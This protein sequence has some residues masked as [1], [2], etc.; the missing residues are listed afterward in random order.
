MVGG[1]QNT[2]HRPHLVV[3][4]CAQVY[5]YVLQGVQDTSQCQVLVTVQ[6]RHTQ[7]G[8]TLFLKKNIIVQ[9][10]YNSY[11]VLKSGTWHMRSSLVLWGST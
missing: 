7:H 5:H 3:V 4:A 8:R 2:Q 1:Q 11:M 6:L 10:S 9:G